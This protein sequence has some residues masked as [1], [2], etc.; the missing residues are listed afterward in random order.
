MGN[1]YVV[2]TEGTVIGEFECAS[3]NEAYHIFVDGNK[4]VRV[5]LASES[6]MAIDDGLPK[7]RTVNLFYNGAF[8]LNRSEFCRRFYGDAD[9]ALR[10]LQVLPYYDTNAEYV[11]ASD[12]S[13]MTPGGFSDV[14]SLSQ[15]RAGRKLK[16]LLDYGVLKKVKENGRWLYCISKEMYDKSISKV[17]VFNLSTTPQCANSLYSTTW[18]QNRIDPN[19]IMINVERLKAI[20]PIVSAVEIGVLVDMLPLIRGWTNKLAPINSKIVSLDFVVDRVQK[21][22]NMS[23]EVVYKAVGTMIDK[24]ILRSNESCV[25]GNSVVELFV[26]PFFMSM[27]S[28]ID[29]DTAIL[30]SSTLPQEMAQ[31]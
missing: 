15:S 6:D 28:R 3:V 7:H 27:T 22:S 26:N 11:M 31:I 10:F 21:R 13:P 1:F 23:K 16:C 18:R 12:Y 20:L 30:F 17:D 14:F 25:D 2:G 4:V 9:M 8:R 5:E 29:A 19:Y 24:D